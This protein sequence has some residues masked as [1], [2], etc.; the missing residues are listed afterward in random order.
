MR[1]LQIGTSLGLLL[2]SAVLGWA[3]ELPE[4]A[5][6]PYLGAIVVEAT[7]GEVLFEDSADEQGYPASVI[8]LM[9]LLLVLEQVDAG[10]LSLDDAVLVSAD[11]SRMGGSQVYLKEHESFSVDELLYALVVQSAN[12]AAAALAERVSGSRD[13][14]VELMAA[15]ASE[16]GMDSTEIH[17]VHGL[18]PAA[19]QQPDVTTAR[20]LSILCR[21]LMKHPRALEYTATQERPFRDG[22]FIMRT[23]NSLLLKVPGCD[24][25]KTGYF[26]KA[27]Y[28]IAATA[29]RQGNRIIAIVLDSKDRVARN[30]KAE[31]LLAYGFRE[32]AR[33]RRE[34]H[35]KP[36]VAAPPKEKKAGK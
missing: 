4:K 31:E 36:R 21:E 34:R 33:L 3:Q 35:A 1:K 22:E 28:S 6:D 9:T 2:A 5:A 11:A 23:H 14:F 20:D 24:G 17:S 32:L 27:G 12:D 18:P 19:G 7:T 10:A 13:A 29:E 30:R 8:K 26:R 16:L 25:L 15:R